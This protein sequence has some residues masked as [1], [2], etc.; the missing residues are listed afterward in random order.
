M[1]GRDRCW[2]IGE[3]LSHPWRETICLS[4]GGMWKGSN[5]VTYICT[6]IHMYL[7]YICHCIAKL[8][9]NSLHYCMLQKQIQL[10][11]WALIAYSF[12]ETLCWVLSSRN[13][14]YLSCHEYRFL[15][16]FAFRLRDY[17]SIIPSSFHFLAS[18]WIFWLCHFHFNKWCLVFHC[19]CPLSITWK[20]NFMGLYCIMLLMQLW[21]TGIGKVI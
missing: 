5:F 9:N 16:V 6:Q 19:T 4:P 14:V 18:V 10:L 21:G 17:T 15:H 1:I 8:W 2:C 12:G 3:A 7:S 13:A 11:C 20:A